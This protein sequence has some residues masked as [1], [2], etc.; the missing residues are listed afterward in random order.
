MG[1]PRARSRGRLDYQYGSSR[2]WV[3]H[4]TKRVARLNDL[5]NEPCWLKTAGEGSLGFKCSTRIS[6]QKV[7]GAYKREPEGSPWCLSFLFSLTTA[8]ASIGFRVD[9]K[10]PRIQGPLV[11]LGFSGYLA[12]LGCCLIELV[13]VCPSGFLVVAKQMQP[14]G[15]QPGGPE[16]P[17]GISKPAPLASVRVGLLAPAYPRQAT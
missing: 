6:R 15:A 5:S 10:L 12:F 17:E 4:T 9:V 8:L 13:P 11:A 2:E 14:Q 7:Y 16:G 3:T 1:P